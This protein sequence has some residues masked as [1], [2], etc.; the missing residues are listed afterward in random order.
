MREDIAAEIQTLLSIPSWDWDEGLEEALERLGR[1]YF[2]KKGRRDAL[3]E[4]P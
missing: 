4:R 3:W 2:Q 1:E